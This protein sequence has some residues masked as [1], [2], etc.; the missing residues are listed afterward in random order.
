MHIYVSSNS[1]ESGRGTGTISIF[2]EVY[3]FFKNFCNF[4]L[5]SLN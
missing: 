4:K 3:Y 5:N 1:D 2:Y